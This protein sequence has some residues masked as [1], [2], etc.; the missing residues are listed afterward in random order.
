MAV[1]ASKAAEKVVGYCLLLLYS[2]FQHSLPFIRYEALM[3]NM[4]LRKPR[5][6]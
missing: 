3:F 5:F 6:S 1:L 2:M 4:N